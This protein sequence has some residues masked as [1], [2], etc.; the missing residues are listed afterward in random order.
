MGNAAIPV[1]LL[2][3]IGLATVVGGAHSMFKPVSLTLA[4]EG[5]TI[6]G[7]NGEDNEQAPDG[8]PAQPAQGGG[9]RRQRVPPAPLGEY[10]VVM[11]VNGQEISRT[12]SILKDEWWMNRR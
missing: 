4:S 10:T 8:A 5:F 1:Q 6:P 3:I 2:T 11:S 12:V 7:G 9:F